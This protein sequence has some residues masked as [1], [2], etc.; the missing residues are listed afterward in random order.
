MNAPE[1]EV[2]PDFPSVPSESLAV[3]SNYWKV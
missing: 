1:D 3:K 2:L